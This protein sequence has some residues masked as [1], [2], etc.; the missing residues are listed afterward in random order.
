MN[1]LSFLFKP[2]V[3]IPI[4]TILVVLT[5]RNYRKLN[6]MK[7][8]NVDS[9]LLM[10]E[11]PK[12]NDKNELSAEQMFMALHGILRDASAIR[13]MSSGVRLLTTSGYL[14]LL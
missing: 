3:W 11:I 14:G 6:R 12:D 13:S 1:L 2:I 10:L 4:V 8:L 7:I 9:V 5:V